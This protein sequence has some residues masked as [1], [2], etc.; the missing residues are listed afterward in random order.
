[1]FM[2]LSKTFDTLNHNL[3]IAKLNMYGFSFNAIKLIQNY[4]LERFQKVNEK[5]N[6]RK[7]CKILMEV[8]Q[9]SIL[10]LFLFNIFINIFHFI[11]KVYIC[12]FVDDNSLYSIEDKF[13][14]VKTILKKNLE[15]LQVRFYENRIILNQGKCHDLIINKDIVNECIE[16]GKKSLYAILKLKRNSLVK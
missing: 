9:E 14:E 8:S 15:F 13:K 12:N 2:D 16:L 3:L 5:Y 7:W 11:Q 1:M 4:L 10:G 6:F